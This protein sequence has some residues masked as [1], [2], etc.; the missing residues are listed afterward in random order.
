MKITATQTINAYNLN[1]SQIV[2]TTI[3]NVAQLGKQ[4]VKGEFDNLIK[5]S[6][7]PIPSYT[8]VAIYNNLA[9]KLDSSNPLHQFA[10]V[11]FSVNGTNIGENCEIKQLGELIL[12]GWGLIPNQQYLAG[13]NGTIITNNTSNSNFTKVIGYAVTSDKLEIIKDSITIN[14]I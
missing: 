1:A 3:I 13:V 6:A 9:Y 5:V 4:G 8:P 7:E 11:G 14:K 10:F 2:K 12:D